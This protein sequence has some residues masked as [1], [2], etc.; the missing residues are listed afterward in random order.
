[1]TISIKKLIYSF[2]ILFISL[3]T[4]EGIQGGDHSQVSKF[5]FNFYSLP[6]Y[7]LANL[8]NEMRFEL[9]HRY[10]WIIHDFITYNILKLFLSSESLYFNFIFKFFNGLLLSI[11]AFSSIILTYRIF[12]LST[13]HLFATIFVFSIFLGTPVICLLTG[14]VQESMLLL[15]FVL[16]YHFSKTKYEFILDFLIVSI[17]PFYFLIIIGK[18]LSR[19]SF[20]SELRYKVVYIFLLITSW[21]LLKL[22]FTGFGEGVN[23]NYDFYLRAYDIENI[24]PNFYNIF[25]SL[26][27]GLV[28]TFFLPILF[29]LLGRIR[30]ETSIKIIFFLLLS[31]FIATVPYW[32]GH[33]GGNRYLAPAVLIFLPEIVNFIKKFSEYQKLKKLVILYLSLIIIFINLPQLE[34]RNTSIYDYIGSSAII[35]ESVASRYGF[36]DLDGNYYQI[37]NI[38]FHPTIFAV[39]VFKAKMFNNEFLFNNNRIDEKNIYPAT[40]L[41]RIL[42]VYEN[43]LNIKYKLPFQINKNILPLFSFTYYFVYLFIPI[44]FLLYAIRKILIF[45]KY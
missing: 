26:S 44:F 38:G 18:V 28:F 2:G 35:G 37:N 45:S 42:Y 21:L 34:F 19:N 23:I 11:Y 13:S 31:V 17:K 12:R 20:F 30:G 27:F 36:E 25:F 22:L 3:L 32:H 39:G 1:M 4:Y 24:L 9:S 7:T 6:N 43:N 29:I 15:L 5:I 40:G 41:G 14:F 33:M 8:S 10:I 16:S